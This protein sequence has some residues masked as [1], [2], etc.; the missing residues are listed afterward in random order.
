MIPRCVVCGELSANSRYFSPLSKK[1]FCSK[2]CVL[3]ANRKRQLSIGI[4]LI[5]LT[6]VSG[7]GLLYLIVSWD[8]LDIVFAP[9][10]ILIMGTFVSSFPISQ[11]IKGRKL[12]KERNFE[13]ENRIYYCIFCKN[14]FQD[15]LDY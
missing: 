2:N 4:F 5:I 11:F 15:P 8:E 13:S 6:L 3:I 12:E 14:D 1:L 10:M 9:I 7:I